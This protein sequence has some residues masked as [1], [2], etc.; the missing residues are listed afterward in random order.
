MFRKAVLILWMTWLAAGCGGNT[1]KQNGPVAGNGGHGG[2]AGA[3][4]DGGPSD[5][6]GAAGQSSAGADAGPGE[7]PVSDGAPGDAAAES[8]EGPLVNPVVGSEKDATL[9][10]T[11][12]DGNG[13]R[14]DVD[15]YIAALEMDPAKA[16]ALRSFAREQTAMMLLGGTASP[17]KA[18]AVGQQ[19]RV[20]KAIDCLAARY[21][22]DQRRG[23]VSSLGNALFNNGQ[24]WR[25]YLKADKLLSGTVL[26]PP[27]KGC[28]T[29]VLGVAQ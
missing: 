15:A 22:R 18:A 25:A 16:A 2:A 23:F 24:R 3:G 6:T 14:D 7:V 26:P 10:G 8:P 21:P 4:G 28:D 27:S 9:A 1:P 20:V 12:A 13:V 29:A 17:T 5:A 19:M 11:D